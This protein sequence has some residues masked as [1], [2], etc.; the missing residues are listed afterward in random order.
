MP[1]RILIP[2]DGSEMGEIALSYIEEMVS[3]LVVVQK[4]E[5][6]LF[7]VASTT[8]HVAV[9]AFGMGSEAIRRPYTEEEL[10]QTKQ[11]IMSYLN[12]AGEGLRRSK[13]EG[14]RCEVQ[15]GVRQSC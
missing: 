15:S 2:L 8:E 10:K 7:H 3:R 6:T 5:V 1:E 4:V 14:S 13:K 9:V 12:R 11:E